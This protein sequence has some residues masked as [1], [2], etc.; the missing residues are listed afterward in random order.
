MDGDLDGF[1]PVPEPEGFTREEAAKVIE[2][3]VC[4]LCHGNLICW[5]WQ[6]SPG[7]DKYGRP[8]ELVVCL[9]HGNVENIG[10]VSVHSVSIQY[11]RARREFRKVIANLPDL[12][13]NLTKPQRS[14]AEIKKILGY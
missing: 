12:W 7:E 8:L 9:K 5:D 1:V 4:P 10:R 11:D 6:N 3:F 13:G 2:K 14:E